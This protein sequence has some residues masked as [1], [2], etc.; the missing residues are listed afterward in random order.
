MTNRIAFV[1]ACTI[2]AA[3]LTDAVLNDGAGTMFVLRKFAD[4]IEY[5]A[6]WR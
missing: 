2:I 5:V 4:L 6:F 1:L 3:I